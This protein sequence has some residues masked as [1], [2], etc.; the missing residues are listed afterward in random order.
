MSGMSGAY[1]DQNVQ[2]T[3]A[4]LPFRI[5][6]LWGNYTNLAGPGSDIASAYDWIVVQANIYQETGI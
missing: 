2:G 6:D 3:T 5:V 1:L 4:T